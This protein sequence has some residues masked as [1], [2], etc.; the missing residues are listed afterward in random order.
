MKNLSKLLAV[1]TLATGLNVATV[2]EAKAGLAFSLANPIVGLVVTFSG[3]AYASKLTD[4]TRKITALKFFL[5]D[6]KTNDVEFQPVDPKSAAEMGLTE[7]EAESY[8][9]EID[10]LN[11]TV[12]EVNSD[13][14]NAPQNDLEEIENKSM[15]KLQEQ[16]SPA[17]FSAFQKIIK[18]SI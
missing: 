10:R 12:D 4:G 2:P 9:D 14:R 16:V 8:N 17:T 11:A 15:V 18:A 1:V 6:E 3:Y 5:L 13:L 7:D